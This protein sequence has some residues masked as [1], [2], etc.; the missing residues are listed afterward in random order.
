MRATVAVLFVS[1][2]IGAGANAADATYSGPWHTHRGKQL[3]GVMT[4]DVHADQVGQYRGRFHGVW[5]GVSFDYRVDFTGPLE[6]LRGSAMI[7]GASYNWRGVIVR[8]A[9]G[10]GTFN[11]SFDGSRYAGSFEMRRVK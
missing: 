8:G 11:A 2:A 3:S 9:P 7:D 6:D 1:L 5:Q 10:N 4:V